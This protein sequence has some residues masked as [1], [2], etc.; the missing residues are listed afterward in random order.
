MSE[1]ALR[2]TGAGA[3]RRRMRRAGSRSV[4][5]WY[6][7]KWAEVNPPVPRSDQGSLRKNALAAASSDDVSEC[8]AL[9]R[10][11]PVSFLRRKGRA[12]ARATS[13]KADRRLGSGPRCGA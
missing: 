5:F 1:T 6:Y 9:R 11:G 12:T 10:Q 2:D 4:G 3:W 8:A 13:L 7:Q